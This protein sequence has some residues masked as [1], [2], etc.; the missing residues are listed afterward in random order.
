MAQ[1]TS[2]ERI[3]AVLKGEKPDRVPISPRIWAWLT[4]RYGD[5]TFLEY[6]HLKKTF[7]YDPLFRLEPALPDFVYDVFGNYSILDDVAVNLCCE[8]KERKL[9]VRR[10]IK[11]PCGTLTDYS[12]YPPASREYGINPNPERLEPLIKTADDLDKLQYILPDPAKSSDVNYELVEEIVGEEAFVSVRPHKGVAHMI[13]FALG[14]AESLMMYYDNR[15]LLKAAVKTLHEY[16]KKCLVFSLER[17]ARMIYESWY[18]CSISSGWSPQIYEECFLPYIIEDAETVHRYGAFFHFYDDGKIMPVLHFLKK[19]DMDLLSTLC[20]PPAGDV[21]PYTVKREMGSITALTGYVDTVT[22]RFGT[23]EEVEKQVKE[24]IEIL[25]KDGGYLLGT[26]DSIRDES[27]YDNVKAFF[28]AG[29]KYGR[30][31]Y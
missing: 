9:Y 30:Y 22:M 26:S 21:D 31:T 1:M 2:K 6:L 12:M 24:A 5:K 7:D 16:Y 28:E 3:T 20:P 15:E 23:P 11:T 10:T 27:P 17:G 25:G 19:V 4:E 18:N 13:A 29:I 8:Q 14:Y